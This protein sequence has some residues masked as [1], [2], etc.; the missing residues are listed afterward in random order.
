[1]TVPGALRWGML[2][3]LGLAIAVAVAIAA[4]KLTSQ[5]IGLASEPIRAGEALAPASADRHRDRTHGRHHAGRQRRPAPE[6]TP[7]STSP[8]PAATTTAPPA[9]PTGT[10]TTPATD[11]SS[12]PASDD[13]GGEV[14]HDD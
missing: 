5:K 11:T 8:P 14:E 1:M 12:G 10:G 7:A 4:S 13:S 9:S 3:L 6:T 2:A